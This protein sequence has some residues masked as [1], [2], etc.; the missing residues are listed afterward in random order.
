MCILFNE[1]Q[2]SHSLEL[3][4]SPSFFTGRHAIGIRSVTK[5]FWG[6]TSHLLDLR[7]AVSYSSHMDSDPI[8]TVAPLKE[9]ASISDTHTN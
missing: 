8:A 5:V 1:G 2:E 6:E 3:V 9:L 4:P 7:K